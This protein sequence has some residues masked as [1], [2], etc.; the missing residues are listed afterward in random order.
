M[1]TI[2]GLTPAASPGH[3]LPGHP[4]PGPP[5]GSHHLGDGTRARVLEAALGLFAVNS[6]AGTSL[7]MIADA[8]GVTKAA[9]YHHFKTRDDILTA[10]IEPASRELQAAIE[11][12]RHRRGTT[13]QA[14]SMLTAFVEVTIRHRALIALTFTD[15]GVTNAIGSSEDVNHLL[16]QLMKLL[17]GHQSPPESEV[18]ATLAVTGLACAASSGLLHHLSDEV[19]LEQLNDAGRRILNLRRHHRPPTPHR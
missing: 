15:A 3:P 5:L 11:I 1:S 18:N 10:V 12:A 19:L 4:S 8:V 6:F 14:E 13:A 17:T 2:A 7:Q 9:V 16:S